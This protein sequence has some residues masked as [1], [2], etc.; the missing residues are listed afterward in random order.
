[1]REG[2]LG[3]ASDSRAHVGDAQ[4]GDGVQE[5]VSGVQDPDLL[6]VAEG[7]EAEEDRL[8]QAECVPH[9]HHV[10][11]AGYTGSSELQAEKVEVSDTGRGA[12][13]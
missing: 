11:Q 1:M 10:L 5:V 13:Y 6:R 9:L 2:E 12:E 3:A 7:A 4:L 8:D